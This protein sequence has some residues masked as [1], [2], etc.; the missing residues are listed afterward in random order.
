MKVGLED[1]L[2]ALGLGNDLEIALQAERR[3]Q[4]AT[5]HEMIIHHQDGDRFL[6]HRHRGL[7]SVPHVVAAS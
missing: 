5:D 2:A 4:A 6:G 7:P 3:D 1:L